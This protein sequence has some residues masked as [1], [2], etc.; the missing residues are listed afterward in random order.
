[1]TSMSTT[2]T[3]QARLRMMEYRHQ[4]TATMIY[5]QLPINDSFRKIDDN[6]VFGAM[7]FKGVPQP[8]FFVLRR[9]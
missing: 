1:M 7:D 6:T 3:S 2:E 4:V 5:D 9:E 8:F